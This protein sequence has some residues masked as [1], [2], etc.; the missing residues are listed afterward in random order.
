MVKDRRIDYMNDD[1]IVAA[2]NDMVSNP[3]MITK[4]SFKANAGI[5]PDNQ[6]S[7]TEAHLAYLKKHPAINPEH[8]LSNLR[9]MIR[10]K[11]Y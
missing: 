2:L 1:D 4:P 5:W 9:L 11:T 6:I 8:Y 10:N 3:N 7:F